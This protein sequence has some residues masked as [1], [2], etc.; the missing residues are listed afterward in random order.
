MEWFVSTNGQKRGPASTEELQTWGR[1]G[2]LVVTDLVWRQGLPEWLPAGN[3]P[4]LAQV[5][6]RTPATRAAAPI[7][8]D[9]IMRA[10]LP[11]GRS[12]WAIA[13]GYLGLFSM[14]F[15]FAPFAILCGWLAIRDIRRNPQK[16]GMG[17]AIF[18]IV[19]GILGTVVLI[20]IA[21]SAAS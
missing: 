1:T 19:M 3:V 15:V 5:F 20:L 13:A 7:G 4:E 14:L 18:G 21:W 8:A 12:G 17:R 11:V 6:Y 9:P 16:H 10:L 2:R